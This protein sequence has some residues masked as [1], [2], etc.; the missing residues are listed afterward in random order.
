MNYKK[1]FFSILIFILLF[2]F[3]IKAFS[4]QDLW[5]LET[6]VNEDYLMRQAIDALIL[7]EEIYLPFIDI[8][9]ILDI[10]LKI[11]NNNGLYLFTRPGDNAEI[12][13]DIKNNEIFIDDNLLESVDKITMISGKLFLSKDCLA[14]LMDA[15]FEYDSSK[16]I[17]MIESEHIIEEKE[18]AETNKIK[19]D[20]E[21]TE[22][23]EK[24]K[25]TISNITYDWSAGWK[26]F[27]YK[28]MN[29]DTFNKSDEDWSTS[30]KVN[31]K[32][33]I[34]DW[35]YYLGV[36]NQLQKEDDFST[37]INNFYM[38][39]NMD[40]ATFKV[41]KLGIQ[42][43]EELLLDDRE[44]IG[45]SLISRESP[46]MSSGGNMIQVKGKAELGAKVTLFVNDWEIDSQLIDESEKYIFK[47]V[48][49]Y[50]NNRANELRVEI[51]KTNGELEKIYRYISVSDAILDKNQVNY[52]SQLGK[53][54]STERENYILNSIV[55]WGATE[56]TTLGLGL[57]SEFGPQYSLEK[58]PLYTYNSLRLNQ[59]LSD[60]FLFKGVLY[61]NHNQ[62]NDENDTGYKV[63]IDYQNQFAQSGLEY[64][65]QAE[66][67]IYNQDERL[68][69]NKIFKYYYIQDL[70]P[71]SVIEGKYTKYEEINKDEI[72]EELYE[73]AY[74]INKN[75]WKG[76]VNYSKDIEYNKNQ[77]KTDSLMGSFTYLITPNFKLINKL[78][79]ESLLTD[80]LTENISGGTKGLIKVDKDSYLLSLDW[81]TE[82]GTPTI[83]RVYNLSWKRNWILSDEE[84]IMTELAYKYSTK[85]N[86]SEIPLTISYSYSF[87]NDTQFSLSYQGNWGKNNEKKKTEHRIIA[88]YGGAFNF[89]DGK[90]VSTSPMSFAAKIGMVSGVVFRDEN[91]N[92]LL[93]ENEELLANIPVK[94][95]RKVQ[96]T[97][98][99]GEFIFKEVS[100]GKHKLSFD[101]NKLPIELT[102][103]IFEK[104]IMV[105][106]N[107]TV[108]ENLGLYVIGTVDGKLKINNCDKKLSL[109]GVKLTAEPGGHE[110]YTDYGGYFFFD[111]LPE[112]K[113]EVKIDNSTLPDWAEIEKNNFYNIEITNKGE[114][115]SNVD[116]TIKVKSE[117]L[118]KIKNKQV[119]NK[120]KKEKIEVITPSDEEKYEKRKDIADNEDK[121][122]LSILLENEQIWAP[123]REIAEA[124]GA[125]VAWNNQKKEV[126]IIDGDSR[127]L[128]NVKFGYA[129]KN[130][131][132]N[133]LNG[134]K[135]N[136]GHTFIT[137]SDLYLLDISYKMKEDLL[138]L[139]KEK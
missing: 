108:N 69:P 70:T 119:K 118:K 26:N 56:K 82:L 93:D 103:F 10:N 37:E 20:N 62:K 39:Y 72:E 139:K 110:T 52:L 75:E 94:L 120:E 78:G 24:D 54:N 132:S 34:Y 111:Q 44:Y 122:M 115:I 53:L 97:N 27:V 135:L 51:E 64:H 33:T 124:F 17:I 123:L 23:E 88:S 107:S 91:K 9:N 113:Y 7:E 55:R 36:V 137:L 116:F 101:Y 4:A 15:S 43:E 92:G 35:R 2:T 67:L 65:Y 90:M 31:A 66:Q 114:Y 71:D 86:Y 19:L 58:N 73:I 127:I 102:P 104:T 25:F 117:M 13:V 96:F 80:S 68:T 38:V 106:A 14:K 128:F 40:Q 76:S 125:Q 57:Y 79:Y 98:D 130:E 99:K 46:L 81:N 134:I 59:K 3:Q 84:K 41:G 32:G 12:I 47:D 85:D 105:E 61:Q 48:L 21:K 131:L 18:E 49:I 129:V 133:E 45:L 30:L 100:A 112:G 16:L 126:Y 77:S 28:S 11:D 8:A 87:D 138:I 22:K 5:I 89:F 74:K 63:N 95:D 83:N 42:N 109:S 6:V 136:D 29:D 60:K 50:Q 1:I 121:E